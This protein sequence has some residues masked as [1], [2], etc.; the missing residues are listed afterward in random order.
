MPS[1]YLKKYLTELEGVFKKV[2]PN[3]FDDF[4]NELMDAYE[5]DAHIFICGN[6]GS[7]STA[8]HFAC[9]INKGVSFGKDKRFKVISLNDNIPIILAY[10]NDVSYDDVFV[11]QLKNFLSPGDLFI[12]ISGS[13]NSANVIKAIHYANA[14][15][16]RT[17]A[18]CGFDGGEL[19]RVSQK[20]LLVGCMDMQKVEDVHMIIIH[21]VMQYL[22]GILSSK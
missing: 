15:G 3:E 2:Q 21:C 18:L 22:C 5:R 14:K 9:D 7:G 13:G 17:F 12:G 20:S 16:G 10:A 19:K 4:V 6:G 8:S 1:S 11:E